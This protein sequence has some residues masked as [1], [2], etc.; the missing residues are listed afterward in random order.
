MSVLSKLG[1][2]ALVT[3]DI[4]RSL[5]FFRDVIGLDEVERV[6]GTIYL[7]AWGE[8]EH[9]S[10]SL[11]E[12][13][14]A[15]EH[16]GLRAARPEAV[17]EIATRMEAQGVAVM[18]VE[19]GEEAG[20]GEAIRFHTPNGGHPFEIYW[21]MDRPALPIERR[22]RM[23]SNSAPAYRRGISPRRLDHVNLAL[24]AAEPGV[25]WLEDE[26]GFGT[27]EMVRPSTGP[28]VAA[29]MAVTSQ[30]H[31][32]ALTTDLTGRDARLH[33]LAYLVDGF[34]DLV[35]AADILHDERIAI[36]LGP[37]MHGISRGCF[38]YVKDP[39][40]GHRVELFQGGYHV[41]DPDWEP[42]VWDENTALEGLFWW[43]VTNGIPP[44]DHPLHITTPCLGPD[45]RP[46]DGSV[47]ASGALESLRTG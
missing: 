40:S 38:L 36:D 27:R 33:H 46:V 22:S 15:V 30:V 11:R 17:G 3:P 19:A 21:E 13:E 5:W 16:I 7:R 10:L 23:L 29:W 32:V 26:L 39:G 35:R 44:V 37:G 20:Q 6:D 28:T 31:D 1:H 34:A 45:G 41:F 43:G 18:R 24:A 25:R 4:E 8:F 2:I 9:H 14:A 42:L 12:G 47:L